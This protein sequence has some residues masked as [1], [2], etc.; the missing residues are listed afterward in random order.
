MNT[1]P[2]TLG[3]CYL[4][5]TYFLVH[6]DIAIRKKGAFGIRIVQ[7]PKSQ[8]IRPELNVNLYKV[9]KFVSLSR[10]VVEADDGVQELPHVRVQARASLI[11]NCS[12]VFNP[13]FLL[14]QALVLHRNDF[15]MKG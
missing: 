4:I 14:F 3:M 5:S 2:L 6:W 15:K 9:D 10:D 7:I 1:G 8:Y 13:S 11:L 12:D